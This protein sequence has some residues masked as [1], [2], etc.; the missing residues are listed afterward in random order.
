MIAFLKY[1]KGCHVMKKGL[2]HS[3]WPPGDKVRISGWRL[4]ESKFGL[5]Y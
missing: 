1:L 2:E 5:I 3:L 4:F